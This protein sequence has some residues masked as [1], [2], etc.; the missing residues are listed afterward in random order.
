MFSQLSVCP[1]GGWVSAPL[2]TGI[3]TPGPE[4]DTPLGRHHTTPPNLDRHSPGQ[5]PPQADT[6]PGRH[7]PLDRHPLP[8]A[9]W[10][11]HNPPAQ[12]MLGH[13]DPPP[14]AVHAEM[15]STSG[16]YAS[17]W[18]AFLFILCGHSRQSTDVTKSCM[19]VSDIKMMQTCIRLYAHILN[20][21]VY[22]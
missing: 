9:C 3:H 11:I 21:H 2:H 4:A 8:S 16:W 1:Q 22:R 19:Q 20:A 5:K 17:H 7:T 12:Y 18:N 10:D 15:R 6:P 14:C 13:T